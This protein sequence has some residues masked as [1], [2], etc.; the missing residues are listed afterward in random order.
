MEHGLLHIVVLAEEPL[1][2][3]A[4]V[5]VLI[6]ALVEEESEP[7]EDGPLFGVCHALNQG[8]RQVAI[9]HCHLSDR[10]LLGCMGLFVDGREG[11]TEMVDIERVHVRGWIVG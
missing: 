8:A 10:C 4:L 7:H 5:P 6:L 9:H 1:D 11:N 3:I 2:G